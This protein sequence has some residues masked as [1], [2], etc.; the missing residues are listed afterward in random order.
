MSNTAAAAAAVTDMLQNTQQQQQAT[1]RQVALPW[2]GWSANERVR[3]MSLVLKLP[4]VTLQLSIAPTSH[5]DRS[6]LMQSLLFCCKTSVLVYVK[7]TSACVFVC[8]WYLRIIRMHVIL[9]RSFA[10]T[11]CPLTRTLWQPHH[12]YRKRNDNINCNTFV[13]QSCNFLIWLAANFSVTW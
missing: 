3:I 6:G 13:K 10:L 9:R 2:G 4:A 5:G 8:E 11:W 7:R 1:Q 12:T